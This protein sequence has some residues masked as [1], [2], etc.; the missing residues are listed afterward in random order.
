MA[1]KR[2]VKKKRARRVKVTPEFI[3]KAMIKK[4]KEKEWKP[5]WKGPEEDGVTQSLL[6]RFLVCRE[7]FR[8]TVVEGLRE[9]DHYRHALEYGQMWHACE[10]EYARTKGADDNWQRALLDYAKQLCVKYRLEQDRIQKDYNVCRTQFPIYL[11]YRKKQKCT[12]LLAE[13]TFEVPYKLPSG[14]TVKLRGK[15]DG[16][17][18]VGAGKKAGIY[19]LEHKTKG[20]IVEEKIAGQLQFDLQT[21]TYLV[22]L[23]EVQK[24]PTGDTLVGLSCNPLKGVI[25]NVV[26]RPLAGGKHSIRPHAAKSLKT[27]PDVPAETMDHYYAR[28][29]GL[30]AEEPEYYF[31]RWTVTVTQAEIERFKREFLDPILEQL[32]EWWDWIVSKPEDIFA[33]S[34]HYRTPYGVYNILAEGGTSPLDEYLATGSM[35]ELERATTLFEELE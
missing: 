35:T 7:R 34:V 25:Y 28:L 17:N 4:A 10:E 13:Q 26:R 21:M 14:R 24:N 33:E 8:L 18:L 2:P 16:V 19:L 3:K 29:G 1:K 27:K 32:C 30:I 6:S 23:E 12:Q 20:Q 5:L 11:D 22:A 15:W 9:A 31:M